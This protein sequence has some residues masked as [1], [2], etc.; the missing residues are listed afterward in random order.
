MAL[1]LETRV[2]LYFGAIV[3]SY[4]GAITL[5]ALTF[6][7]LDNAFVR[8]FINLFSQEV[9]LLVLWAAIIGTIEIVF[10]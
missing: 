3:T 6:A 10:T 8:L 5:N 7:I 2:T 4:V 9:T 1:D